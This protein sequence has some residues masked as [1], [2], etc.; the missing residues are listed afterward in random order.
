L[1]ST[2]VIAGAGIPRRTTEKKKICA[3]KV[4]QEK[5]RVGG[6][7]NKEIKGGKYPEK[8]KKKTNQERR[9]IPRTQV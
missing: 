9:L 1:I 7:A 3:G 4:D 2:K 8:G 6:P 5:E